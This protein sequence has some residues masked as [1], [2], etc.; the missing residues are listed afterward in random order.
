VVSALVVG[1]AGVKDRG[2]VGAGAGTGTG[3]VGTGRGG[4]S[5][6]G[7]VGPG[8]P[9]DDIN[10]DAGNCGVSTFPL[11][12]LPPDVLIV[13]DRSQ[14]MTDQVKPITDLGGL[15]N[16]LLVGPC[17][18]K[19]ADMTAAI[20]STVASSGGAI[21]WGLKF[22]PDDSGCGVNPGAAVPVA[23]NNAA[24]VNAA[25]AATSPGGATPTTAALASAGRYLASLT[26]PNSRYV[27]LATDGQPNCAGG[28]AVGADDAAAIAAVSS[29]AAAGVPVFV[30]GI[31]TQS[32][33]AG[34]DGG[35]G[36]G[37]GAGPTANDT[38]NSMARAGGRP[39]NADPAYYPV[40][41]SADLVAALSAIGTQVVSCAFA[42]PAPPDPTNIGVYADGAKIPEDA[43]NGWQ[44]GAG[45]T[46]I[47]LNGSWCAQAQ[48]G[49]LANLTTI[50][51]CPGI[52][53]P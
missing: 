18:T 38:L 40:E 37:A 6:S 11:Q 36:A 5:G 9:S 1:C 51:G 12:R 39:R 16:C 31:A 50:F 22:F 3:G 46:S 32:S 53:V 47:Q 14:S 24:P 21:N 35:T 28:S 4:G 27:V 2:G 42:I 44:Y 8:G 30:I 10:P 17:P 48:A 15:L 25:I 33:G 23:P 7:A 43:A 41:V 29:L 34:S 19:W 13:L 49:T 45:M 20:N 26:D 52:M